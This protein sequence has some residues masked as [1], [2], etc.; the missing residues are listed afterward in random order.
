MGNPSRLRSVSLKHHIVH[1]DA[2][3]QLVFEVVGSAGK[4]IRDIEGG[5]IV[6]F[7]SEWRGRIVRTVEEVLLDPPRQIR[8]RWLEG[9]LELVEEAISFAEQA[10]GTT[11][12]AYSGEIATTKGVLDW[13]RLLLGVRPI[14]NRLVRE[15]LEQGKNVAE[16]RAQRSH[17]YRSRTGEVR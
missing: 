6:E 10:D 5:A 14:F 1:V 8:Y 16:K 15:H 17:L 4:K 7:E 3:A 9:P 11:S 12:M 13:L 2:P